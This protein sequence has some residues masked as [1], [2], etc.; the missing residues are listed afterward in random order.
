MLT[1]V[2]DYKIGIPDSSNGSLIG[3]YEPR[4]V[5]ANEYYPFGML[6]RVGTTTTGQ[7]Y[8]HLF[9]GQENDWEIKGW[10]NSYGAQYWEYD[11]RIGR[12]W[13]LDPRPTVGISENSAFNN[14]PIRFSDPLGDTTSPRP[15]FAQKGFI[16]LAKYKAGSLPYEGNVL[17]RLNAGANNLVLAPISN[18]ALD[19]IDAVGNPGWTLYNIKDGIVGGIKSFGQWSKEHPDPVE[20]LNAAVSEAASHAKAN[21]LNP[22]AH[23]QVATMAW[24]VFA[25]SLIAPKGLGAT[26]STAEITAKEGITVLG[27]YPDYI[28]LASELGAKRFNI[29]T[30]IWN[31][32]TATEQWAANTKFLDRMIARGDKII[33]SNPVTDINKVT[34]AFRKELDYLIDKGYRL[35]SDGTQM[36]K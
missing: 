8:R 1:T 7:F 3:Y 12:R 32:M 29:P 33:L 20:G 36:I 4:I 15:G 31:K 5:S 19:V 2:N 18:L 23:V 11:S 27:K 34:G 16:D 13:N 14:N 10:G 22:D 30:N 24:G 25:G 28:N 21:M 9:N 17:N 35:N 26:T 6:M